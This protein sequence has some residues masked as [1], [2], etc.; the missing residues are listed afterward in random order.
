MHT[1]QSQSVL[2]IK[3]STKTRMKLYPNLKPSVLPKL[4]YLHVE[5][6]EL[7]R[8]FRKIQRCLTEKIHFKTIRDMKKVSVLFFK[9]QDT[10]L[11]KS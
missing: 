5:G 7:K 10:N 2:M 9:V 1:V 4:P 6:D 8:C 3:T 11:S